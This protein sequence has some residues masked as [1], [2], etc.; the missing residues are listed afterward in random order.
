M[1]ITKIYRTETAHI[2]REAFSERCKYNI[3]G[4]SYLWE[5]T[6]EGDLDK[7]GMAVDFGNLAPIKR[8]VDLFDHSM[9]MWTNEDKYSD[10]KEFFRTNISRWIVMNENPTAENMANL[11]YRYASEFLTDMKLKTECKIKCVTVHETTTGRA[12]SYGS[13]ID[14]EIDEMSEEIQQ[15]FLNTN[16]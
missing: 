12:T 15:D 11:L 3:H 6:I 8:F 1:E 4:H 9:V 13:S 10:M 7:A 5:V 14:D 2:V 16:I